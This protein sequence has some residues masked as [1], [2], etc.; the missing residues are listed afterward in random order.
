M[1]T[2]RWVRLRQ[3]L[4]PLPHACATQPVPISH[5]LLHTACPPRPSFH[6][7]VGFGSRSKLDRKE[8]LTLFHS[9]PVFPVVSVGC[10]LPSPFPRVGGLVPPPLLAAE[11]LGSVP[12]PTREGGRIVVRGAATASVCRLVKHKRSRTLTNSAV[13]PAL[14]PTSST[15]N[16]VLS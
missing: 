4:V 12:R 5:L 13:L 6:C 1:G 10:P 11:P 16:A 15:R 14:S 8:P 3:D 9:C 2:R 7:S